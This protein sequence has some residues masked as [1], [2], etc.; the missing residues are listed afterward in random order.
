MLDNKMDEYL[1][2]SSNNKEKAINEYK[3]K[4]KN[5]TYFIE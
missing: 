2:A 1:V 3:K 4:R 5:I